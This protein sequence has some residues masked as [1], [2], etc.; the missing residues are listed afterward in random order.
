FLLPVISHLKSTASMLFILSNLS[1]WCLWLILLSFIKVGI[2]VAR[3]F[4]YDAMAWIYRA[5]VKV[6]DWWLNRII[7]VSWNP[8]PGPLDRNGRYIVLANH[9]SW[10]DIFLVQSVITREGPIVKFLVKRELVFVPIL[11][12][13]LWAFDFPILRRWSSP[14]ED[15]LERRDRD[16]RSL[17]DACSIVKRSPA[18][19]MSFAEGTRFTEAKRARLASPFK[20][21]L[22]PR[23]GGFTTAFAAV[24]DDLAGVIDLTLIYPEPVTFWAFL[25][26]S[27]E[28]LSVEA[29]IFTP[30][31]LPKGKEDLTRWLTSRWVEKDRRLSEIR[32]NATR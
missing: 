16:R 30:A 2:P 6:D 31:E 23:P 26:G 14:G 3:P 25:G 8:L 10:S 13:I 11:G 28:E 20:H 29:R 5:A 22:P 1:F 9:R 21:L 19:L 7:G 27:S 18:A 12:L 24:V 32:S 4:A 17:M 15:S